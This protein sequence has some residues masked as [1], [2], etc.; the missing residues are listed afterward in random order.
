[1]EKFYNWIVN[2]GGV[3]IVGLT[4]VIGTLMAAFYTHNYYKNLAIEN[5]VHANKIAIE[6]QEAK[7]ANYKCY[8]DG[9]E[10]NINNVDLSMYNC[11]VNNENKSVYITKR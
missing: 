5:I 4:C 9:K 1:M 2:G 8:L 3:L 6:Q 7:D 10:I 11:K